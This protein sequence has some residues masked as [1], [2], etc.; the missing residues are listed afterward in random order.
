MSSMPPLEF[1]INYIFQTQTYQ[2]TC[3]GDTKLGDL[4]VVKQYQTDH[5]DHF[6]DVFY[7][8]HLQWSIESRE[9]DR[10]EYSVLEARQ[11]LNL[12]VKHL[13]I[14]DPGTFFDLWFALAN[15]CVSSF[16]HLTLN[17]SL[18]DALT[19][20]RSNANGDTFH[21]DDGEAVNKKQITDCESQQRL[22]LLIVRPE[23][24]EPSCQAKC[25]T[26]DARLQMAALL[27]VPV[28]ASVRSTQGDLTAPATESARIPAISSSLD[29]LA[30]S[31]VQFVQ[32]SSNMLQKI[33]DSKG[34]ST[35][36]T[37]VIHGMIMLWAQHLK[38]LTL[39]EDKLAPVRCATRTSLGVDRLNFNRIHGRWQAKGNITVTE[40]QTALPCM[41]IEVYSA[42]TNDD[43]ARMKCFASSLAKIFHV[44]YRKGDQS[45]HTVL[46]GYVDQNDKCSLYL[47]EVERPAPFE[48]P[49]VTRYHLQTLDLRTLH[50]TINF[51]IILYQWLHKRDCL[52]STNKPEAE[53]HDDLRRFLK[54]TDP[55][56][57]K[58]TQTQTP[59]PPRRKRRRNDSTAQPMDEPLSPTE[60]E[61]GFSTADGAI[62]AEHGFEP[63][64]LIQYNVMSAMTNDGKHVF[65]KNTTR[66]EVEIL[67]KL[68]HPNLV[69][70]FT[71]FNEWN[72]LLLV[73]EY[74][75][76]SPPSQRLVDARKAI[77][78]L[79]SAVLYCHKHGI[80]HCDLKPENVAQQGDSL[81]LLDFESAIVTSNMARRWNGSIS[82][83]KRYS[84]PE[85]QHGDLFLDK[86]DAYGFGAILSYLVHLIAADQY[87]LLVVQVAKHLQMEDP[88]KRMTALEAYHQLS[89]QG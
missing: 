55:N 14:T 44:I 81:Y 16:G 17:T 71:V 73:T 27:P 31:I 24:L 72:R 28:Q 8:G 46:G 77:T 41:V 82:T 38:R 60:L 61:H 32:Y 50:D 74:S 26:D 48:Y 53:S 89:S 83:T 49:E 47:F 34:T 64:N 59:G 10:Q 56:K 58:T 43:H 35:Q 70:V 40:Q 66:R 33:T 39:H 88:G 3:S 69:K 57:T 76:V 37:G 79:L 21:P 7:V 12:R 85:V 11:S 75:G 23:H 1:T 63:L 84:A 18:I 42:G 9:Q 5:P 6:L 65:V 19:I 62:L 30:I 2:E 67:K 36:K 86:V 51:L 68:H 4:S 13:P 87:R 45:L 80:A 78:G 52:L 22:H 25:Q 20:R 54:Q 15:T 29:A